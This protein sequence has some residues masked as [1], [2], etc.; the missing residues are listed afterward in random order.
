MDM[1]IGKN[2]GRLIWQLKGIPPNFP[3]LPLCHTLPY[4]DRDNAAILHVQQ[5]Y[6]FGSPFVVVFVLV[7]SSHRISE[8][9]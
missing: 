3:L 1:Y 2:F 4:K 9:A 5:N 6:I 7:V 8:K